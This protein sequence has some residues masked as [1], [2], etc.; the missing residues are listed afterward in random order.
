MK[1][2]LSYLSQRI[3]VSDLFC[4]VGDEGVSSSSKRTK[5]QEKL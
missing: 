1:E 5:V 3:V 4:K 2:T